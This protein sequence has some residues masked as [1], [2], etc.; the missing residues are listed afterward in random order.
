MGVTTYTDEYT[1]PIPPCRLF[2]ALVLDADIL[3]PKLMPDALKSIDTIQGGQIISVRNRVDE[4]DDENYVYNYTLIEGDAS[5]MEKVEFISYEVKFEATPEGGSKNRMVSKYHTKGDIVLNEE[6]MI[7]GREKA[8]GMY[9]VVEAYL[10]QNPDVTPERMFK[11]LILDAHNLCPKLMFSSIKS[12]EFLEGEGEVGTIKQIN[13]TE[14][15]PMRYAKHRIDAL[16]KENLM[17]RYTFIESDAAEHL[18]DKLEYITYDVKFEGYGRG[19][20]ICHLTSEYKA[21]DGIQI[22]EEDIELGK[23][24]AIGMYEVLEAYLMAHPHHPFTISLHIMGVTSISQEFLCPIAPSRMFKA[25]I[26]DSKNL[27]PKLLPQFI[28]SVEVTQGDGGAGSIEQVNF[29]EGSHFK[30]VKHRIDELDQGNFVC[31]YTMIEGDALGDKLESIGYEVKF[32]AA[33][34]G[35]S[36]CKM[37]SNYNTIGEAEVK[38]EEI[39]A[40]KNSAMGIYK[41][42]ETYLLENP[43]VYS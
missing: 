22:K 20:C 8:L 40:G 18:L 9:K 38:E 37:T 3:V 30:Y 16:D 14:A 24:R 6:D 4:V 39:I 29:T 1:S 27:I 42:V 10:L 19:G 11:A 7:S 5:V 34:D 21:K 43:N 36:I 35:S 15:S 23:D 28:A 41:V 31:K 17:C 2:K 13:F 25:L 33:S 12:I 32:E 26:I